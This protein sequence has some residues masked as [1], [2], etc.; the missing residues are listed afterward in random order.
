MGL[1]RL[2]LKEPTYR[3]GGPAPDEVSE[4]FK[5]SLHA[6]CRVV[7]FKNEIRRIK[8]CNHRVYLVATSKFTLKVVNNCG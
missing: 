7:V 4:D 2:A 5:L 8:L 6:L 1:E 3:K